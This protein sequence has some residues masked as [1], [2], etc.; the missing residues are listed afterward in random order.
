[1]KKD[2]QERQR[3]MRERM[4]GVPETPAPETPAKLS[5]KKL[6]AFRYQSRST[7]AQAS[8]KFAAGTKKAFWGLVRKT[9][10]CWL[11]FGPMAAHG[12]GN[13]SFGPLQIMAHRYSWELAHGAISSSKFHVHHLCKNRNC[14]RPDHLQLVS[15]DEHKKIHRAAH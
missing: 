10:T 12:Y 9:P 15:P 2:L 8:I 3:E 13:F 14:V 4:T 7:S 11:W 1:V 5:A 6:P